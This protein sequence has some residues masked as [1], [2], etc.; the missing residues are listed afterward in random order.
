[1][2]SKNIEKVKNTIINKLVLENKNILLI[3]C[4]KLYFKKNNFFEF[5]SE[6]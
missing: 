6:L 3:Y 4:E 2:P 5:Y 1:M